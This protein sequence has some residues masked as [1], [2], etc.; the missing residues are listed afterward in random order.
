MTGII[1]L[2]LLELDTLYSY[3]YCIE[4]AS[5]EN[6]EACADRS[7]ILRSNPSV[8]FELEGLPC[9]GESFQLI[10]TS[11]ISSGDLPLT[12]FWDFGDGSTSTEISP[13]HSYINQGTYTITL[14]ATSTENCKDTI[15]Q[16]FYITTVPNANFSIIG[17]PEGCAPFLIQVNN[18]SSGDSISQ[19][20]CIAGDTILGP[21]LEDIFI[22]NITSD[23]IFSIVLKVE[24]VCGV[25]TDEEEVLVHPYPIVDFGIS[26]D[27][28]CS[29]LPISFF[30]N[31]QGN[32]CL[33][34]TSPSP[35]DATLSRM[36][37]SA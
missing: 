30:N 24:N 8:G 12:Y 31:T 14:I 25:V 13:F 2:T 7:F 1:D 32:A 6:C 23:S 28:G 18:T 37:S 11:T 3:Q 27:E 20:W 22:D 21:V 16:D 17:D 19:S 26:T 35:R 36:P 10:N 29:P 15:T 34:Y 5:V 4:S 33:L 9:I